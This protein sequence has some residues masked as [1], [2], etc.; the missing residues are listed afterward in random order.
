VLTNLA[1][2]RQAA[3]PFHIVA[4]MSELSSIVSLIVAIAHSRAVSFENPI[5][6]NFSE[7]LN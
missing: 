2:K 4:S 3:P 7:V 6:R 5:F 1:P